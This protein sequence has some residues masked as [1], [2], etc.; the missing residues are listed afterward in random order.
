MLIPSL[1]VQHLRRLCR[2][3]QVITC[4]W[5]VLGISVAALLPTFTG[6]SALLQAAYLAKLRNQLLKKITPCHLLCLN[7]YRRHCYSMKTTFFCGFTGL[8]SRYNRFMKC[9][10]HLNSWPW[11]VMKTCHLS[12]MG[13]H[14]PLAPKPASPYFTWTCC[15]VSAVMAST[16]F[17]FERSC[18]LQ[19]V[20]GSRFSPC[21]VTPFCHS[22]IHSEIFTGDS[23]GTRHHQRYRNE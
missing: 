16:F 5:E 2:E 6:L 8:S 10:N 13:Q 14:L 23:L 7:V 4:S 9:R 20:K 17:L 21:S 11:L 12:K 1:S 3:Q 22:F 18:N 19:R 15:W